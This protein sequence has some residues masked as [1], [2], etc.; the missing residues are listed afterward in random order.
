MTGSNLRIRVP[1]KNPK[2]AA[3]ATN[4]TSVDGEALRGI[5]QRTAIKNPKTN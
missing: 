5:S 3:S 2:Q 4:V 1:K